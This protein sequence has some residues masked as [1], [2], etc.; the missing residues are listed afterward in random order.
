MVSGGYY[1]LVHIGQDDLA[2]HLGFVEGDEIRNIN[3]HN[4][5]LPQDYEDALVDLRDDTAFT[6][7][8][9]RSG[10]SRTLRYVVVP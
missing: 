9:V 2:R 7:I 3:G 1:R 4:L 8:L 5:L 10:T 6:V